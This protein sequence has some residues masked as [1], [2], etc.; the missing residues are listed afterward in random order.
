MTLSRVTNTSY[1]YYY[2][3]SAT[4]QNMMRPIHCQSGGTS[5]TAEIP[6]TIV[7]ATVDNISTNVSNAGAITVFSKEIDENEFNEPAL[8]KRINADFI[9]ERALFK[10]GM[11]VGD[12]M[13]AYATD[14]PYS[15]VAN[16][17]RG[18]CMHSD[19]MWGFFVNFYNLSDHNQ[20]DYFKDIPQARMVGLNGSE[21]YD[22]RNTAE[23]IN[24][25]KACEFAG[26]TCVTSISPICHYIPPNQMYNM[27]VELR[28]MY[29]TQFRN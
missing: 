20:D 3:L 11:S 13:Y 1:K 24:R 23:H 16:W 19:W 2:Y 14:Q 15:Q 6:S 26:N 10:E 7:A 29:P 9:G 5:S 12:L 18:Y 25:R 28:R 4:I 21:I 22:G 17:T 27:S 8:C